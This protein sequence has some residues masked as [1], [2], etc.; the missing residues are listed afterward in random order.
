ME[1]Y[2]RLCSVLGTQH[3]C[4][5]TI[6]GQP[7]RLFRLVEKYFL[8]M[9]FQVEWSKTFN[10][11]CPEC[12]SSLLNFNRFQVAVCKAQ[13]KLINVSAKNIP[14]E[15]DNL[16][17]CGAS[18]KGPLGETNWQVPAN[19]GIFQY[20]IDQNSTNNN[21]NGNGGE[22][23]LSRTSG[24]HPHNMGMQSLA[25]SPS[26]SNCSQ[27][28]LHSPGVSW[29]P[30]SHVNS[31]ESHQN[32]NNSSSRESTS[33][34]L[35]QSQLNSREIF[36]INCQQNLTN[37]NRDSISLNPQ[38]TQLN[39]RERFPPLTSSPV[40]DGRN[41]LHQEN[42]HH[43]G[44]GNATTNSPTTNSTNSFESLYYS[45]TNSKSSNPRETFPPTTNSP[46]A[47]NSLQEGKLSHGSGSRTNSTNSNYPRASSRSSYGF[48]NRSHHEAVVGSPDT[49][50]PNIT[51]KS[52]EIGQSDH[53]KNAP[54][55][56]QL[57]PLDKQN[58][59]AIDS[60]SI[61]SE[62][63][64]G[65]SNG[66]SNVLTK[67]QFLP[68]ANQ[69][70]EQFNV[71]AIKSECLEESY[72]VEIPR[73]SQPANLHFD[74]RYHGENM[75]IMD[76]MKPEVPEQSLTQGLATHIPSTTNSS[77]NNSSP[78]AIESGS[79]ELSA[80][81]MNKNQQNFVRSDFGHNNSLHRNPPASKGPEADQNTTT[82]GFNVLAANQTSHLAP[83]VESSSD[84]HFN[85]EYSNSA[86][87]SMVSNQLY[88]K[89]QNFVTCNSGHNII[90]SSNIPLT[91]GQALGL[92]VTSSDSSAHVLPD[93]TF[94]DLNAHGSQT[95]N[96][97][98]NPNNANDKTQYAE[99]PS[100]AL[101]RPQN[102]SNLAPND[103]GIECDNDFQIMGP[104][105]NN[106]NDKTRY[107]EYSTIA[108][109]SPKNLSNLAPNNNGI[110]CD[111]DFQTMAPNIN[112]SQ[113]QGCG[114]RHSNSAMEVNHSSSRVLTSGMAPNTSLNN[115]KTGYAEYSTLNPRK[116]STLE[117]TENN[118]GC[119]KDSP[120]MAP[121]INMSQDHGCEI[122][123][124]NS[125]MEEKSKRSK[126]GKAD[127]NIS[128]A[129]DNH[130]KSQEQD[131][132]TTRPSTT[133]IAEVRQN[134]TP[135]AKSSK[136]RDYCAE[137]SNEETKNLNPLAPN[138]S[139]TQSQHQGYETRYRKAVLEYAANGTPSLAPNINNSNVEPLESDEGE[140][141]SSSE[142]EWSAG[143]SDENNTSS[144]SSDEELPL[145]QCKR[146][147]IALRRIELSKQN[148]QDQRL[149]RDKEQDGGICQESNS[150]T[151]A[152]QQT[153]D[154]HKELNAKRV[155]TAVDFDVSDEETKREEVTTKDNKFFD[156][157]VNVSDSHVPSKVNVA[158][159]SYV[160]ASRMIE[161]NNGDGRTYEEKNLLQENI[162][163]NQFVIRVREF[164]KTA[165][166]F[167]ISDEEN[168][169]QGVRCKEI[170]RP[171]AQENKA[172]NQID[173]NTN[174]FGASNEKNYGQRENIYQEMWRPTGH[175]N[176]AHNPSTY[177][178]KDPQIIGE[179][180]GKYD[181]TGKEIDAECGHLN[182]QVNIEG[183][184]FASNTNQL[185]SRGKFD[186]FKE[187]N[188]G[189]GNE[190]GRE[191][192]YPNFQVKSAYKY[193]VSDE[194]KNGKV[195]ETSLGHTPSQGPPHETA[196]DFDI[197][198]ESGSEDSDNG[199][200]YQEIQ[201]RPAFKYDNSDAETSATEGSFR[202]T[203]NN[204]INPPKKRRLK[205]SYKKHL[206][207]PQTQE[208]YDDLIAKWRPNLECRICNDTFPRFKVLQQHFAQQHSSEECY[209]ECC[210]L[211][212]RYRYELEKHVY[213][214]RIDQA[215][216]CEICFEIFTT[217]YHL[218]LH[219]AQKHDQTRL[220]PE[221]R[222]IF[223]C[224]NC[225]KEYL[226]KFSFRIHQKYCEGRDG[227]SES[228]PFTCKD[229]G[230]S[231]KSKWCLRS[232][233]YLVHNKKS[234]QVQCSIC[235]KIYKCPT[236]LKGHMS[237]HRPDTK[238]VCS[239]CSKA[240]NSARQMRSHFKMVH[241]KEYKEE[242]R[243]K[244]EL[245][246]TKK[247]YPCD[248]CNKVYQT[249][250]ALKEHKVQH[251]G[252]TALYKCKYCDKEY[253]Y[254]SNLSAHVQRAH[255]SKYL[256]KTAKEKSKRK[257]KKCSAKKKN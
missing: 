162:E 236:A 85:A 184:Q 216:K 131:C 152:S 205:Y 215:A 186:V 98:P 100:T 210:Q 80:N 118:I 231:Y 208:E 223:K 145:E 93:T 124:S 245:R 247:T 3:H 67:Q 192:C 66:Q 175:V 155:K 204:S 42:L 114:N 228:R 64:D 138:V 50:S 48:L 242:Q 52:E 144:G 225:G 27:G 110:G 23:N 8:P 212:L 14:I 157:L 46:I 56:K 103:N 181:A 62:E 200:K 167:D 36:S 96:M 158:T 31:I 34:A 143:E 130:W 5:Y 20:P 147:G 38:Q 151:Q 12:W 44:N 99:Y 60:S 83:N 47:Q 150:E 70:S 203:E 71:S 86:S 253:K 227:S 68:L 25:S 238:Y 26:V 234:K 127:P 16:L 15:G 30:K 29:H 252:I 189:Q 105:R 211:Q 35:P 95:S 233:K 149:N 115:E 106:A 74:Q 244:L 185:K 141:F 91:K 4:L 57:E 136:D 255:P 1:Q 214:H 75:E 77:L 137:Q 73:T 248:Q 97:A 180:A 182:R 220:S 117:P 254:S 40:I 11:I 241:I 219:I 240:F 132:E 126:D 78:M 79:T 112:K 197:S 178:L 168:N 84:G 18:S 116:A 156:T 191:N 49:Q 39:P 190:T 164:Q 250:M 129:Y 33:L 188:C 193:D 7:N 174:Q 173:P 43:Q 177:Q 123:H 19:S 165:Y 229:C 202:K 128:D 54:T 101:V 22:R 82:R 81:H 232:H 207:R 10:Y 199:N 90:P 111:N 45:T 24:D 161:G 122:E 153:I 2:C 37:A 217:K 51:I 108:V 218:L 102:S 194:E 230:K 170:W 198:D 134:L 239:V 55:A 237:T 65:S 148:T 235:D 133:A 28:T 226:S 53:G 163:V 121:N 222:E 196:Y 76:E 104:N 6:D 146:K 154:T 72:P 160:N 224:D 41:S 135:N 179:S 246:N 201:Y 89:S 63:S 58:S 125:T 142:S 172:S 9:F 195:A 166:D 213:Y 120:T 256:G 59:A 21:T 113:D 171:N 119:D 87:R 243:K 88:N 251:E 209:I 221:V 139:V 107:A 69:N 206:K 13:R 109:V 249:W 140:D 17:S 61:K 169:E 92:G 176:N 183:H 257:K 32:L 159:T 187:K 94:N